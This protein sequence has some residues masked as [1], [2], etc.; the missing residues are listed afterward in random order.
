[1]ALDSFKLQKLKINVYGNRLRIGL[2]QD[3]FTV[4][5]NPTSISMK[6]ENKFQKLQGINTSGR[7]AMY[8]HSQ[9]DSLTLDLII[10]GTGVTDFGLTN[11]IGKGT[12]SVSEQID[13]FLTL[14]FHMDGEIHEPKFLKIQW[15]DGVLQDFD[16]RLQSADI[17][18][19]SFERSGKPLRAKLKAT[20]IEDLEPSKRLRLEGKKS[21]D[22]SRSRIVKAGDTLPLLSKEVYGSPKYYLKLAQINNLDDFRNLT[23]GQE[24]IFPPLES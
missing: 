10:D 24:L 16:C 6:H 4:M 3:T 8:S 5:F 11:W 15:G 20:F 9:S 14:C 12:K 2:P 21:P 23:P 17:E 7:K 18:Y 13:N 22:I 19:T 1:M